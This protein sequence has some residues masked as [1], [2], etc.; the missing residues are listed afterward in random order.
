MKKIKGEKEKKKKNKRGEG[1]G[2]ERGEDFVMC[3]NAASFLLLVLK[4][5]CEDLQRKA[6]SG[7]IRLV[8]CEEHYYS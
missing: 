6:P 1:G 7:T 5:F 4:L 2:G 8:N 3:L